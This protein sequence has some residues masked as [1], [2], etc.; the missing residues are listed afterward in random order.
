MAK[1]RLSLSLKRVVTLVVASGLTLFI[2]GCFASNGWYAGE[3]LP[4]QMWLALLTNVVVWC[5]YLATTLRDDMKEMLR[6][7]ESQLE[8]I[9]HEVCE[10][11]ERREAKGQAAGIA[12][13]VKIVGQRPHNGRPLNVVE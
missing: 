8:E 12:L 11:G 4:A 7:V 2:L 5:A 1:S 3:R 6:P 9:D 10:Y 13:G